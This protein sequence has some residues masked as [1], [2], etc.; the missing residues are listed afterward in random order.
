MKRI[1]AVMLLLLMLVGCGTGVGDGEPTVV[2]RDTEMFTDRDRRVDY[3]AEQAIAIDLNQAAS[4]LMIEQEGTYLLSGN[5]DGMIMVDAP[6][7]AKLQIVFNGIAV[8]NPTGA[9]LYVKQ[10]DKVFVTLA[11]GTQNTLS[12]GGTFEAIDE[13][14]IDAAIF[15]KQ[16]IT[17][18]GAGILTVTSPIGHGI[19]SKDDLV[20]TSGNYTI[21]SASH[22]LDANDSVRIAE[23]TLTVAAGKDGIHA[24]NTD[25]AGLGFVYIESGTLSIDS[26]GDGI[27]AGS[28]LTVKDGQI[29]V[30]AGGGYENGTKDSSDFYGGFMGG[31][32]MG[33]L[34]GGDHGGGPRPT[35]AVTESTGDSSTSMKGLKSGTVMNLDGGMFT[36]DSADDGLHANTSLTV[37]DGSYAIASGD[38]GIHAEDTLT[39]TGGEISITESYEGLEALHIRVTGGE[40]TLKAADDGLNAAGGT[41]ASGTV[42]G[43]DGRF[44]GGMMGG[45]SNG[46]IIISGGNLSIQASGDG[47]DANGYLEITGGYTVV[48]GPTRGDT[49]TLDYDTSAT[50]SGGTFIGTG[51]MGMA[52]TFSQNRQGVIAVQVG[53]Q[54]A[55]T[56]V[57]LTDA[58]GKEILTFAPELDFAVVI[59]S[60]PMVV[61]GENYKLT[62]GTQSG[63]FVAN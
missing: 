47:I 41:D 28:D 4:P 43:R 30:L 48:C 10:A 1:L 12:N 50:I 36:I 53:Q 62:V 15:S 58:S 37:S 39:V 46:S 55:G 25:D 35:T 19:V 40:V 17:F 45:A 6:D 8:N 7:T 21:H 22:G 2:D 56:A 29:T 5:L 14:H 51:A 38:D 34:G 20:I 57:R 44:S 9:A 49:A 54:A 13:N 59:L 63:T 32:M 42:G 24:E 16:D 60:D 31:G 3:D 23:A 26:Q 27:S 33:G 52:Q 11:D 61:S 18:N